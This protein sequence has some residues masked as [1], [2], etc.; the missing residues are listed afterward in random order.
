MDRYLVSTETLDY[1]VQIV[2]NKAKNLVNHVNNENEKAK[3]LFYF[4]RDK[5]KYQNFEG[6]PK[7]EFFKASETL[8][9]GFGFCIPK[10]VL[11]ASMARA[12][13]IPARIHFADILNYK[14][15]LSL[16]KKLKTNLFTYHAYTELYI[17][18]NWIKLTPALNIELC[19]K[20]EIIP[21]EFTGQDA[22]FNKMDKSGNLHIEYI[23]DR[24]IFD[25][26]PYELI[27]SAFKKVYQL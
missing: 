25:D 7:K 10:A 11:L 6:L 5:I 15:P 16:E 17:D 23:K 26:L 3:I 9:R 24:G 19:E 12:V 2:Q 22:L 4:V 1:N 18:N 8:K 14:I 21:V 13:Q 20:F 27:I